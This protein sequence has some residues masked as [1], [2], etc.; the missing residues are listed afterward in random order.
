MFVRCAHVYISISKIALWVF[1]CAMNRYIT[2]ANEL[3]ISVQQLKRNKSRWKRH[4]SPRPTEYAIPCCK[5]CP[6]RNIYTIFQSHVARTTH[7]YSGTYN[8]R[9]GKF[10][11][12]LCY[13]DLLQ[14]IASQRHGIQF[15]N[16][17]ANMLLLSRIVQKH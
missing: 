17:V 2:I 3:N 9:S 4:L 8:N 11:K 5:Y 14:F 13:K 6:K 1:M 10:R 12:K 15:S 16:F 7:M